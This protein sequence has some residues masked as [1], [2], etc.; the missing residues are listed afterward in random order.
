MEWSWSWGGSQACGG[1]PEKW[2]W[3]RSWGGVSCLT[4]WEH[5]KPLQVLAL[6][7]PSL[8][9]TR[10]LAAEGSVPEMESLGAVTCSVLIIGPL[11]TE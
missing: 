10:H 7:Q 11:C 6:S 5:C 2:D 9:T 1:C 4:W 3:S 8:L